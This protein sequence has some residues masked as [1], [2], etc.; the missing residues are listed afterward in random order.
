M[1]WNFYHFIFDYLPLYWRRNPY[2]HEA[3]LLW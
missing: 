1:K 2:R 3:P